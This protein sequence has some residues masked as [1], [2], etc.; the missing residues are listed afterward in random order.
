MSATIEVVRF[1]VPPERTGALVSGHEAARLAIDSVSPGWIWSRLGRFDER[2]W[3]EIV[4]W[5]DRA[6]FDRALELSVGEPDAADW[7]DLADP[8]WTIELGGPVDD[9][10][11]GP[12]AEG[13][14]VLTT[15]ER[16]E[17]SALV[18]A[19]DEGATWSLLLDLDGRVWSEGAWRRSSPGL[20]RISVPRA[21]ES[22]APPSWTESATIVHSYDAPAVR[23]A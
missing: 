4:A 17:S 14:L 21:S 23:T 2:S 10:Q 15:A 9:P 18:A 22:Q 6:A 12:P 11:S 1:T 19:P 8:D 5:R 13:D 7:F 3:I 20:L 16:G